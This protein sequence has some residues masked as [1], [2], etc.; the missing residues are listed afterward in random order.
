RVT[1]ELLAERLDQPRPEA[2]CFGRVDWWTVLLGPC[3]MQA[4]CLC[5][6]RPDDVDTPV[7]DGQGA[8]TSSG[9]PV[10]K[11]RIWADLDFRR[12]RW[13]GGPPCQGPHWSSL[14]AEADRAP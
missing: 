2:A 7:R 11:S 4:L 10:P 14:P 3:E 5:I 9:F 13:R 6:Q 1:L 8:P 12:L